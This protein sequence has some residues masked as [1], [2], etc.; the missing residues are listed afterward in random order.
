MYK[1]NETFIIYNVFN[2]AFQI[3]ENKIECYNLNNLIKM[4]FR[5]FLN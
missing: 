4:E 1:S 3:S 2:Y 5:Y